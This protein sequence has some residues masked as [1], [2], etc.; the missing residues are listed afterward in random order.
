[1][2]KSN[3][4]RT[5][6]L[7]ILIILF[8]LSL[9]CTCCSSCLLITFPN[10]EADEEVGEEKTEESTQEAVSE[11]ESE[12]A[13]SGFA[14]QKPVKLPST[15]EEYEEVCEE[16]YYS[17]VFGG[18]E[19]LTG[20]Y[21]KMEL[22]LSEERHFTEENKLDSQYGQLYRQYSL[23]DNFHFACVLHE[24]TESY[25][26]EIIYLW[27]SNNYEHKA[28]DFELGDKITIYGKVVYCNNNTW[29]GNKVGVVP[30]FIDVKE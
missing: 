24:G 13:F 19:D 27:Y 10:N 23:R 6:S 15:R 22:F 25:M 29:N 3:T 12:E 2:V 18:E 8:V 20:K 4:A 30:K 9:S 17:D 21:V 28:E 16:L 5:V 1:M 14:E 11:K 7:I 26:G